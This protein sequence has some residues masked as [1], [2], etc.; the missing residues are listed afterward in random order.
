MVEYAVLVVGAL[1]L[2]NLALLVVLLVRRSG[3]GA[4]SFAPI[5]AQVEKLQERTERLVR[6]EVA[7]NREEAGTSSRQTREELNNSLKTFGDFLSRQVAQIATMQK[8]QFDS[9]S[10]QLTILTQSNEKKLEA[11]RLTV[12]AKLT[13]MAQEAAGHAVTGREEDKRNFDGFCQLLIGRITEVSGQQKQQLLE[14]QTALKTLTDSNS[15][16]LGAMRDTVERKLGQMQTEATTNNAANREEAGKNLKAFTESLLLQIGQVATLQKQ[17]LEKF[18]VAIGALTHSNEQKLEAVRQ[19]VEGKLTAMQADNAAKLELMRQTVDEKLHATLELRLGE[20]FKIVSERLE[21]VHKGLGEMQTLAHGV[22]DLKKVLSNIKTR[23]NWGEV[24]LGNLLE[25]MLTPDQYAANVAVNPQ[26]QDRVEFAVKL[27]GRDGNGKCVWLP[28]DAKFPQEDYQRLVDAAEKGQAEEVAN[29]AALLEARICAEAKKIKDKYI[30]PPNTTDFAILFLP[31]EGLFAEVLRRPGLCDGLLHDHRVVLA[32]PTTLAAVLSSLQMGF[33]TLVIEKRS[34]EVWQVL[35]AV[36]TEF[37]KFGDV[38][39]KV[40]K[41]L[42]EASNTIEGAQ[43]RKRAVERHLRA[44]EGLSNEE[45]LK[46]LTLLSSAAPEEGF[47]ETGD[48]QPMVHE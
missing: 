47:A 7:R 43:T 21:L 15:T 6:E 2:V 42:H 38:L 35:G 48:G 31:T 25:Q 32:G 34:S 4:T 46:L 44:V 5:L 1:V 17:E 13:Q 29:F 11:V 8:G 18:S 12:E 22:G 41:K 23:G 33:R 20:S 16:L 14:F 37:G 36:K 24:Q 45:S 28:I 39:E 27:P 30:D 19:T 10:N 9:F 26:T 40:Q 3:A